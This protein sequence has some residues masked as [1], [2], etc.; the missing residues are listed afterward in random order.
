MSRLSPSASAGLAVPG[1]D[2]APELRSVAESVPL[3]WPAIQ[4]HL[5]RSGLTL[6]IDPLPQQFAGGLANLNF[7]VIVDGR[8]AV[9]RRPPLGTLPPGAYDM[10]REFRILSGLS[11]GFALAPR[12]IHFC[13]D[14]GVM[15]QPFQIMEYRRGFAIRGDSLP[16]RLAAVPNIGSTLARTLMATLG[17]IHAIDPAAVGL[18]TLGRPEGFLS[19]T[20]E[21]WIKRAALAAPNPPPVVAE[22]VRWL[23][24]QPAP[25][26]RTALIHNDCKLDNL[27]L[28]SSTL[29]PTAVLDW[30]QCTRGD[31]LF[32][33]ATT[34]SYWTEPTDPPAMHALRQMPSARAGFFSRREAAEHYARATGRDLADFRFVRVLA[35]FKLAV[36]LYQLN[37]RYREGVSDDPRYAQLGTLADGIMEFAHLVARG[38][39]F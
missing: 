24:A 37:T 11:R 4:A 38:E 1:L 16:A 27:L 17:E 2:G 5:A 32:D 20:T 34:L 18:A 21:G 14:R 33:L 19:R 6:E 29:R 30:D 9:L 23:R 15:G 3:P 22:L 31:A 13:E 10:E 28:D 39:L 26:G 12:A 8:E 7:L 25:P 36:I 35:I